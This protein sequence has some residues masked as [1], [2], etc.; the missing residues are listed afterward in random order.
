MNDLNKRIEHL[1]QQI[2]QQEKLASLGMLSA[3]IVHEIQNPL[4]FVINFSKLSSKLLKDLEEALSEV[5]EAFPEA[6]K[7]EI[8][9]ILSDLKGNIAKIEENGNRV[10]NIIRGIL[11]YSRGKDDYLPT[12]LRELVHEYVWLSY[13]AVRAGYKNF[14]VSIREEYEEDIPLVDIIP[15]DMSRAVLNI[16]NNACYAVYSK[17]KAASD[18]SYSPAIKVSVRKE[19]EQVRLVIEDNGTG[20]PDEVNEKLYTP[21]FTTKPIG[22]GTGLGLSISKSIIEGKHN[23]TIEMETKVNEFTRFTIS[24][25]LSQKK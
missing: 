8:D 15:Q 17:L 23:G 3:G 10:S 5:R 1:E 18:S 21:F 2:S 16:M 7:E 20:I 24:L 6:S 19:G 25:P 12:D 14:N 4:N 11:L 9:D 22:E 13:H